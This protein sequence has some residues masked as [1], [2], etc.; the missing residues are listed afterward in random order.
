[1]LDNNSTGDP[2]ETEDT[3]AGKKKREKKPRAK[4]QQLSGPEEAHRKLTMVTGAAVAV[5]VVAVG[6][7]GVQYA[8]ASKIQHELEGTT[9]SVVV[10]AEDIPAGTKITDDMLAI[11]QMPTK[12][13]PGDAAEKASDIVNRS[14]LAPLTKG[15]PIPESQ[16]SGARVPST[17]A[18]AVRTGFVA[19]MVSVDAP[20]GLVPLL[21]P[22]DYV[23]V[24]IGDPNTKTIVETF[25]HVRV[26]ACDG[27]MS[28]AS[29]D[30]YATLT[31]ELTPSQAESCA[32]HPVG[33]VAE[34]R[35]DTAEIRRQYESELDKKDTA[36]KESEADDAE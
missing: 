28:G 1:M 34:S 15:C 35:E 19:K 11:E 3:R 17:V 8:T 25:D 10:P 21:A 9:T 14:T 36:T 18:G 20:N 4:K 2:K 33:V 32:T 5:A 16:V 26:V 22:G 29:S 12:F 23:R 27:R 13:K 7:S 6:F 30:G 31:L 24:L